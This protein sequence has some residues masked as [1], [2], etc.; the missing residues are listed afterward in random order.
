M[1]RQYIHYLGTILAFF[2]NR[3]NKQGGGLC[4]YTNDQ[5]TFSDA[6]HNPEYSFENLSITLKGTILDTTFV[7]VYNPPSQ[8]KIDFNTSFDQFIYSLTKSSCIFLG[9]FNIDILKRDSTTLMFEGSLQSRGYSV[10]NNE[11][12]RV[13]RT[14]STC[15]DHVI[16]NTSYV[17]TIDTLQY[18]IS[19]HFPL[20][21]CINFAPESPCQSTKYRS[22]RFLNDT[23]KTRAQSDCAKD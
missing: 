16:S 11:P 4:I 6:V 17:D 13:T 14:S 15:I 2:K 5:Y 18:C 22:L 7:V 1:I 8:N 21:G 19:D 9:D 12:T 23:N 10:L 20:L 3:K